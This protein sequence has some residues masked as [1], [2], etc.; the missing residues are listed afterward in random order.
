MPRYLMKCSYDG[1]AFFGYQKQVDK[2]TVQEEIEKI[3][4]KLLNTPTSIY[5]SGRTDAGVHAHGQ[6]FHFDSPK[7]LEK[8]G[9]CML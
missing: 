3:I 7:I 8:S 2:R 9:L 6:Y 1:T 4:S 5:A